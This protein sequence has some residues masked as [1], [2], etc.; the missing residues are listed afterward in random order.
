[1]KQHQ[2]L[3]L[4]QKLDKN[5]KKEFQLWVKKQSSKKTYNI[6]AV[7]IELTALSD[8]PVS[9]PILL[10]KIYKRKNKAQEVKELSNYL[11]VLNALLE[12]FL[13]LNRIKKDRRLYHSLL[14]AEVIERGAQSLFQRQ[15]KKANTQIEKF[16]YLGEEQLYWEW[17]AK[18]LTYFHPTTDKTNG[19]S[20]IF[21]QVNLQFSLFVAL[22]Q[23]K[24][25]IE[26]AFRQTVTQ[27]D[28]IITTFHEAWL[29]LL[30]QQANPVIDF[31]I[32]LWQYL[33]H[34]A[35]EQDYLALWEKYQQIILQ[36]APKERLILLGF[37]TNAAARLIKQ[38][39]TQGYAYTFSVYKHGL[40][41]NI[42]IENSYL[43]SN[44]FASITYLACSLGELNWAHFF[45]DK[46]QKYLLYEEKKPTVQLAL[47][48]VLFGEGKYLDALRAISDVELVRDI[49]YK[50]RKRSLELRCLVELQRHPEQ[51]ASAIE[52]DL[53]Y[54]FDKLAH[55]F[56][57]FVERN[58]QISPNSKNAALHF[59][60][61]TSI[62]HQ[63]PKG[64]LAKQALIARVEKA[65]NIFNKSWLIEKIN[66]F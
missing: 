1:M 20:E 35:T 51:E 32:E 53:Q 4:L 5:E 37:I 57:L 54:D 55:N 2:M 36:V 61:I 3:V 63:T 19:H 8:Q 39:V 62:L 29:I 56:K 44:Q 27:Q 24:Y 45:V 64:Q 30:R 26:M 38:G 7:A 11:S 46:Y 59:I 14:A 33:Q 15:I 18:E 42:M 13:L 23:L 65:T 28:E 16:D 60:R 43:T 12:E 9:V 58:S 40:E 41:K 52:A 25:H 66:E 17:K 31:H 49:N 21:E 6:L 50:I 34:P 47:A 10:N 48:E 22:T